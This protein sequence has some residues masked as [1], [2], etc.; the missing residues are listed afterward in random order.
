MYFYNIC[1]AVL[2]A[3]ELLIL[4]SDFNELPLCLCDPIC[5]TRGWMRQHL[6]CPTNF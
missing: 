4:G 5:G 6:L 2:R 1:L 3:K